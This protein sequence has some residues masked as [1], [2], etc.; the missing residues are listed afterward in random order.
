MGG[1]SP[2]VFIAFT[3]VFTST[4]LLLA[5]GNLVRVYRTDDI[6]EMGGAWTKLRTHQHRAR[7]C[8]RCS[9]GASG[10]ARTTRCPPRCS[11]I[12]PAGGVFSGERAR[13]WS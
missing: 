11:G 4:L 12:D 9:R 2:G 1:Y 8:G 6:T 10:S 7:A 5:V 13:L 3:S